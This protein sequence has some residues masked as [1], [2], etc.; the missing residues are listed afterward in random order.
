[1]D[2]HISWLY[3]SRRSAS[4]YVCDRKLLLH[5]VMD[6]QGTKKVNGTSA[7]TCARTAKSLLRRPIG[8]NGHELKAVLIGQ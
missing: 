4:K 8:G 1:M 2:I 6:L 5:V 7:S 3:R